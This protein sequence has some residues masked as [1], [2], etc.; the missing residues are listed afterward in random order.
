MIHRNLES[1]LGQKSYNCEDDNFDLDV[2]HARIK[3]CG[4]RDGV[5]LNQNLI[6]SPKCRTKLCI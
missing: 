3:F 5:D 6:V 4:G 1:W 2:K